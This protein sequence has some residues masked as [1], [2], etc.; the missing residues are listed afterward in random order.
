MRSHDPERSA[1]LILQVKPFHLYNSTTGTSHG[2][3]YPYDRRIPLVFL[4]APF[5]PGVSWEPASSCDALP[6]LFDALGLTPP[7]GLDGRVL[8]RR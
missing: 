3:P 8:P 4:G 5:A 7:P 2:S 6:T 1:D